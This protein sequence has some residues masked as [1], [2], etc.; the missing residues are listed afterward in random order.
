MQ[1]ASAFDE[2][3]THADH[4]TSRSTDFLS[5]LWKH[6]EYTRIVQCGNF[7][8]YSIEIELKNNLE[9][10]AFAFAQTTHGGFSYFMALR[11]IDG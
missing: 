9:F 8:F 7:K 5:S 11:Q 4:F 10:F 3:K 6:L 1:L 2:C